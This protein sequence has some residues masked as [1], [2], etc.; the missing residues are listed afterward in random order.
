[1]HP[2]LRSKRDAVAQGE[3]MKRCESKPRIFQQGGFEYTE[4]CAMPARSWEATKNG[5][6]CPQ[7]L[8]DT[9]ASELRKQGWDVRILSQVG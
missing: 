8:C 4:T 1:M 5:Y 9:H 2:S 6:S 7:T 3:R